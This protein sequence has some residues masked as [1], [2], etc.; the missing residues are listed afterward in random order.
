VSEAARVQI[1]T[2]HS[3]C[4][5]CH[6]KAEAEDRV[7]CASCL[8]VH[9]AD[10]WSES[11]RCAACAGEQALTQDDGAGLLSHY[12]VCDALAITPPEL[13]VLLYKGALTRVRRDGVSGFEPA[14]L[15]AIRPQLNRLL[16]IHRGSSQRHRRRPVQSPHGLVGW[17]LALVVAATLVGVTAGAVD[18]FGPAAAVP[19]TLFVAY[20]LQWRHD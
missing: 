3:R 9:H 5:Y 6:D 11:G 18:L 20:L 2:S 13:E 16:A 8:A 14:A 1:E 15:Q 4:P 7:A 17:I 12:A 19:L 10:C